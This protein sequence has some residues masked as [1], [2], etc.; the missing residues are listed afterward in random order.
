[1][2]C[3]ME[4]SWDRLTK[5]LNEVKNAVKRLTWNVTPYTEGENEPTT[6]AQ[7]KADLVQRALKNWQPE[8]GTLEYSFEDALYHALD[9]M[10][11]GLSVQEVHWGMQDGSW[12]PRAA[13]YVTPRAYGWDAEGTQLGLVSGTTQ[14]RGAATWRPF[15]PNQFLVGQWHTRTG[16]PG[17]TALLRPLV[18]YWIGMTYGWR[19]LMQ[20]AQIFGIPFRWAT[21]DPSQPHLEVKV[22]EMLENLGA[23]GWAAFPAGTTLDFKEAVT[24]ARDNPQALIIEMAKK[25]C[26]LAI[27]GQELSSESEAAGLG[28]GNAVLQGKVRQDVLHNAAYWVADLVNYQLVSAALRLNFGDATEAPVIAPDLS[29]DPDPKL[30][31]ERDQIL[32]STT[33]VQFPKKDF[34]QRHGIRMPEAGEEVVQGK[35]PPDPF[36]LGGGQGPGQGAEGEEPKA[37][38]EE[39][40]AKDEEKTEVAAKAF[41]SAALEAKAN[42]AVADK[43]VA[44]VLEDLTGV[45]AKWLGGVKPFFRDLIEAARDAKLSDAQFIAVLE[46]AQ[47]NMPELFGKLNLQALQ[48]S[49]EAAMGAACV[50]GAV[51]GFMRR[52]PKK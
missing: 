37:K 1:M 17:A 6:T 14:A 23:A 27:L 48:D 46:R 12:L 35:A 40:G 4:D 33:D 2:F 25:A 26:D 3:T 39:P 50:N 28:S 41:L 7:A 15:N 30:L 31:A 42:D 11:K 49:L 29:I 13:H 51:Q 9:A 44:N 24:N 19:W 5:C 18:P 8:I 38:R 43:L 16:F 36:G 22:G 32:L 20:T 52:R 47:K 45:E 10:G 21:Y 34:Y